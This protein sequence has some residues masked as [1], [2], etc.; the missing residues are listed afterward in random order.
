[1]IVYMPWHDALL[2]STSPV[3]CAKF[4]DTKYATMFSEDEPQTL[5]AYLTHDL[6]WLHMQFRNAR[7][8]AITPQSRI[9]WQFYRANLQ[10]VI[11]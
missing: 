6:A 8:S 5:A 10:R 7:Y 1:M 4:F 9:G 2:H 11:R 3:S